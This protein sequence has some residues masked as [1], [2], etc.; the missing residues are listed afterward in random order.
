M[1]R[2]NSSDANLLHQKRTGAGL[3][4]GYF[5]TSNNRQSPILRRF[6]GLAGLTVVLLIS[7]MSTA[8]M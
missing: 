2:T 8:R 3:L 7:P 6:C 5:G 4:N 1:T